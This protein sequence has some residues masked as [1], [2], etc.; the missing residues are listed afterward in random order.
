M[1]KKNLQKQDSL[2]KLLKYILGVRPDEFGLYPDEG[3]FVA[4]KSLL[5]ALHDEDGCRG[6]REGQIM[7]YVNQPG[8]QSM[9]EAEEGRIRLK[10]ELA[11]LPPEAPAVH[12]IPKILYFALK[13]AAWPVI[14]EKGLHPKTGETVALL[15]A[16]KEQ[17]LKVGK[18]ISPTPVLVSIQTGPARKG[19][20]EFEP[21]SEHLWLTRFVEAKYLSGPPVPPKEEE[22][23]TRRPK[24]KVE[25]RADLPGSFHIHA[26]EPEVHK[27]KKKGKHGDAPDWK[28]QTRRDR[29]RSGNDDM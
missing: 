13:P 24:E 5:S 10:P 8:G 28:N 15:W 20:A 16:D 1:S 9:F 3:G 4:M 18:R 7:M 12:E 29:R 2:E 27:G 26:P 22:P 23:P 21:Y 11:S 19:A 25:K 14:S 6:V 17:A